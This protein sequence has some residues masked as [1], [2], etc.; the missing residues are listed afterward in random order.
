MKAREERGEFIRFKRE[1]R[2]I[3]ATTSRMLALEKANIQTL[4]EG[5]GGHSPI[6][7]ESTARQT[8]AEISAAQK[9]TLN[10][11]QRDALKQMLVSHDRILGL[12]GG[13]GTGCL[14][15]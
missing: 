13:A 15:A 3:E 1:D 5:R 12:Q 11:G 14:R 8:I 10:D 7:E 2:P 9:V 4:I 6:V